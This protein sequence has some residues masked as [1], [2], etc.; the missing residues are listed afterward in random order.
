MGRP[1]KLTDDQW[2]EV[3]RRVVAGESMRQL[4]KEFGVS[5]GAIRGRVSS[6]STQVKDVANQIVSANAALRKMSVAAQVI[7]LDYAATLQTI[8]HNLTQA[9]AH[10]AGTALRLSAIAN[11]QVQRIDEASPMDSQETLQAISALTKMSND[12][13]Q[14]GV[15]L[16]NANNKS[17]ADQP[18]PS[19]QDLSG[20]E[21]QANLR[22]LGITLA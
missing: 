7:T 13:A 6:Q 2:A 3:L 14:L 8:S 10:S 16:I 9:A 11:A 20:H 5:E 21:V 22:R 4:A 19:K 18:A 12:A 17:K 1:S 15:N